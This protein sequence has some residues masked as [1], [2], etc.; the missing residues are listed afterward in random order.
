M[1]PKPIVTQGQVLVND[2]QLVVDHDDC[3]VYFIDTYTKRW[4]ASVEEE[5]S[6]EKVFLFTTPHSIKLGA[7]RAPTVIDLNL[8]ETGWKLYTDPY[9]RYS[10]CIIAYRTSNLQALQVWFYQKD[11]EHVSE[12]K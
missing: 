9:G 3:K 8:G 11:D 6:T 1:T 7:D 12:D 4:E 5:D 2:I 10:G